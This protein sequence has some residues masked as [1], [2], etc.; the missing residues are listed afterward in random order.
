MSNS[1]FILIFIAIAIT[2][3]HPYTDKQI[4]QATFNGLF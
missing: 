3:A 1:I 2:V 4:L